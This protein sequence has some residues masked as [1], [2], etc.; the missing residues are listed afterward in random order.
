MQEKILAYDE[1]AL[2]VLKQELAKRYSYK[3][4]CKNGD[5]IAV[6]DMTDSHL[7]HAIDMLEGYLEEQAVVQENYLNEVW[8]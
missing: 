6:E 1:L 2:H 7:R 4:R 3:W 5:V 8:G